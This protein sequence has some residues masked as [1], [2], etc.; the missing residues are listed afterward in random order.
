MSSAAYDTTLTAS[1][2]EDLKEIIRAVKSASEKFGLHL[3]VGKTKVLT[4]VP[5]STFNVDG[6]DIE[7]VHS[8]NFLGST[9]S[10]DGDCSRDYKKNDIG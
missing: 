2:T 1:F 10:D 7:V 9:I 3:N 8:F 5:L 6:M 4:N